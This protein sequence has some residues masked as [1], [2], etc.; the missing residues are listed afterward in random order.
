MGVLDPLEV[1]PAARHVGVD[2]VPWVP[3][4]TYPGTWMR[5]MQADLEAGISVMAGR[6][7][8]GLEVGTHRH[9]GAVHM[10]TL[11]GA[12]GYREHD[13]V[14]RAGSYL[15][16]PPG[17]VHTL[18]VPTDNTELTETLTV[19]YGQTEYLGAGGE[20]IAIT[21]A[22]SNLAAY[23]EACAAAGVP[24]PTGIIR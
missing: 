23:L 6:L 20:I 3:N 12:W 21:N 9:A 19:I 22:A 14:N 15:Y 11:S 16:E 24:G 5:L 2:D 18:Y 10:F 8:P 17:S 7:P 13:Y 4:P 1:L